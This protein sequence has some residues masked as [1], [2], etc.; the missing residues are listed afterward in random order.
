MGSVH[1]LE[2]IPAKENDSKKTKCSVTKEELIKLYA[3]GKN[4]V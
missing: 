4:Q 3:N 2:F 1:N